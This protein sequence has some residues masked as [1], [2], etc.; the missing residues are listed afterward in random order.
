MTAILF[1]LTVVALVVYG[2]ERNHHRQIRL[3]SPLAGS[4]NIDDRDLPRVQRELHA[5][6][7]HTTT[8]KP[9]ATHHFSI[10]T[11]RSA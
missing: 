1:A 5:T 4:T 7:T 6:A 2:L 11:A 3:G 10:S 8:T 9:R